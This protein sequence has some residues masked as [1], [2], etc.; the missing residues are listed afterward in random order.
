MLFVKKKLLKILKLLKNPK[1]V[2]AAV[3][4]IFPTGDY[5][6][7]AQMAAEALVEN[8]PK[9]FGGKLMDDLD[10]ATRSEIYAAVIGPVQQNA[11][12]VSRMKKASKPT[13]TLEGIEK[14]G[15]INISD[16]GVADEFTRFM[17]ETDPKGFK[18]L[19]QKIQ[20]ESFD[21]KGRKKNATGGRVSLSAG[22][23]AGML[24]E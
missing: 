12:M 16:E 10:D 2:R 3:D 6:Y 1:K 17:K 19:E 7:D 15:T 20:I 9:D 14:T 24:G 4:D 18:D 21:P 22:G 23:L 13:K 8:N 5:K 11:L